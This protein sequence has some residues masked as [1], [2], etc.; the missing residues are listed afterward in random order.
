MVSVKVLW[1]ACLD[2]GELGRGGGG[3]VKRKVGD[4]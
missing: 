2:G 3:D 4:R 1:W